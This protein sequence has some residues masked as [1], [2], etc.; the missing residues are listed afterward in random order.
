[1]LFR[2]ALDRLNAGLDRYQQLEGSVANRCVEIISAAKSILDSTPYNQE[3]TD[4]FIEHIRREDLVS[5]QPLSD[6][7]PEWQPYFEN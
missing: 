5:T 1:M 7:V 3:D 6:V 2:S 4:K